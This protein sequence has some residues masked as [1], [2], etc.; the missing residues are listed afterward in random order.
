[1]FDIYVQ[2]VQLL[3]YPQEFSATDDLWDCEIDELPAII[4]IAVVDPD[5]EA[6][7]FAQCDRVSDAMRS[8]GYEI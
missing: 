2:T 8:L 3:G 5:N 7:L 1:M 6:E 4:A